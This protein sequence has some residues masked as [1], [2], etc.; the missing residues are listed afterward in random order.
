[1][2]PGRELPGG[3]G[4][5]SA[6]CAE[7]QAAGLIKGLTRREY[8]RRYQGWLRAR[9]REVERV[10]AAAAGP[11]AGDEKGM[12]QSVPEPVAAWREKQERAR[13]RQRGRKMRRCLGH[14]GQEFLSAGIGDRI[15]KKCKKINRGLGD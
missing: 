5:V 7:N 4:G 12:G 2:S 14:C 6:M 9:R 10:L 8:N 11:A 3:L 13:A 15:C 1:M